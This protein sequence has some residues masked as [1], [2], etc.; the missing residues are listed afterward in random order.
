MPFIRTR[1]R[2]LED[3]AVHPHYATS[4][5]SIFLPSSTLPSSPSPFG[6]GSVVVVNK[7]YEKEGE[8]EAAEV[9]YE[10]YLLLLYVWALLRANPAVQVTVETGVGGGGGGGGV[11]LNERTVEVFFKKAF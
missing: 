4:I 3:A 10:G 9:V 8:R 1:H 11:V 6:D 5:C 7:V 2:L